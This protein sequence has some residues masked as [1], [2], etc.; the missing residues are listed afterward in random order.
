MPLDQVGEVIVGAS[1][2]E[3]S[4]MWTQ[5]EVSLWAGLDAS[6][7]KVFTVRGES[8]DRMVEVQVPFNK[9]N[10]IRLAQLLTAG[11]EWARIAAKKRA[12]S[13]K[14]LGCFPRHSWLCDVPGVPG[15]AGQMALTFWSTDEG[16]RSH[17]IVDLVDAHSRCCNRTQIY[18]DAAKISSLID[19]VK[20]LD[21]AMK[22]ARKQVP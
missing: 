10:L 11:K 21:S 13:V 8:H 22:K 18:V 15:S 2:N 12:E 17:L 5:R 4:K 9:K 16:Q 19:N 7:R 3:V 20:Q 6:N 14:I 1:Y